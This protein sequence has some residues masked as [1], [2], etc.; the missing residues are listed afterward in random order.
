MTTPT[1]EPEADHQ[2]RVHAAPS[3]D[4]GGHTIDW[5]ERYSMADKMWSGQ[6]N[7]ALVTEVTPLVPGTA[8]D[9]GCGEGADA[10]WLAG[11]GW[12]VTAIDVTQVALGRASSAAELA[13]VQVDWLL[14]GLLDVTL[15]DDGFDLVSVQYPALPHTP[16]KDAERTLLAAVALNG[17]LVVVH[18]ADVDDQVAK[19]HGFDPDGYVSS[20]DVSS[21]LDDD[22]TVI[23]NERRPRHLS[24]GAGAGHT[25]DLVLHAIRVR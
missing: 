10:V 7:G 12:K 11:L 2:G 9:V 16:T 14:T 5:D 20:P 22:W 15:P 13:N 1:P 19:A 21:L 8:L 18:H 23:V 3:Q 24:V 25:H 17:H 6:P 4:R